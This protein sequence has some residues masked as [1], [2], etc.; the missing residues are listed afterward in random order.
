M[1][2]YKCGYK[3][4]THWNRFDAIFFYRFE[5]WATFASDSDEGFVSSEVVLL[6]LDKKCYGYK[7]IIKRFT[8]GFIADHNV[9]C[10]NNFFGVAGL[11]IIIFNTQ[12]K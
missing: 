12:I 7:P 10:N 2:Y 11:E 6:F 8:G 4:N 5:K 1:W 9:Y 3:L